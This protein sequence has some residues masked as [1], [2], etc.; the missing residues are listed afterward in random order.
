V[1]EFLFPP[2]HIAAEIGVEP[3]GG[4]Q[5]ERALAAVEQGYTEPALHL[6]HVL[7]GGRLANPATFSA[8]AHAA[9]GCY[10]SEKT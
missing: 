4:G 2:Q 7:A 6:L 9:S 1:G 10:L 5:I 3:A 8:S